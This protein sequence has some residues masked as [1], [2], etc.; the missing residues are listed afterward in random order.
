MMHRSKVYRLASFMVVFSM[1]WHL[2]L[3]L[4]RLPGITAV[5]AAQPLQQDRSSETAMPMTETLATSSPLAISRVQSSYTAPGTVAIT[6]TVH[7]TLSPVII[8]PA[9]A[10]PT[11]TDTLAALDGFDPL[12]D[13]NTVRGVLLTSELTGFGSLTTVH[14]LADQ[15][16]NTLAWNLGDIAPLQSATAVLTLTLSTTPSNIELLD[17]GATAYGHT[18]GQMVSANAAPALV[19]PA[20]F[21]QWLIWTLDAD[22]YNAEML[23]Q[24]GQLGHDPAQLFAYVQSLG[25]ELYDGSLRGTR[26]TLW[27]AAGN[28]ADQSSLLIAMLRASGIPTRYRYGTLSQTDAQTLLASMFPAPTQY[29]GRL[30]ESLA[31][32]DPVNDPT[33]IAQAQDHWWVEAY[34]DDGWVDLDP[35]FPTAQIGD[36]FAT[37]ANDGTDRLAELPDATRHKVTIRLK[38]EDYYPLNLGQSGLDYSY[39]LSHTFR[40][41]ELVAEPVAFS[42]LVHTDNQGGL[43]F[44]NTI[45]TYTPYLLIGERE[46]FGEPY[47]DILTNF[48]LGSVFHTAAWLQFDLTA[49]NGET[50]TYEREIVDKIG[51]EARVNGGN[52]NVTLAG[53]NARLVSDFDVYTTGFW[54][55]TVPETAVT[56]AKAA[57]LAQ[58]AALQAANLRLQ[59]LAAL[60]ELTQ[61]EQNEVAA[62]RARSQENT[63]RLLGNLGLSFAEMSDRMVSE[64]SAGLFIKAYYAAPRLI[65]TGVKPND[66]AGDFSMDLRNTAVRAIPFPGQA[67]DAATGFN[68]AKGFIESGIE[69]RTLEN[70]TGQPVLTTARISAAAQEQGIPP[71]YLASDNLNLLD[72]LDLSEQANARITSAT[73]AGKLVIIPVTRVQIDGGEHIGWWEIDPTSGETIGVIENG[74]HGALLEYLGTIE[75][76]YSGGAL[77]D[78]IMGMTAYL[79]GF[80]ADRLDKAIGDG[81]FDQDH[82]DWMIG[83]YATTLTCVGAAASGSGYLFCGTGA[84]GAAVGAAGGSAPLDPFAWGQ[85]AAKALLARLVDH[86]PPLPNTWLALDV[87]DP[88]VQN[89]ATA[90]L[91]IAATLPTGSLSANLTTDFAVVSGTLSASY[92]SPGAAYQYHAL[93]IA[94]GD[95]QDGDG[96]LIGSGAI[97]AE[98]GALAASAANNTLAGSGQMAFYAAA[99][100]AIGNGAHFAS[101][102]ADLTG[103]NLELALPD[104][105]VTLNTTTYTGDFTIQTQAVTVNG[106]GPLAAANHAA[107]ATLSG[108]D[109]AVTL[110]AASGTATLN[111]QLLDTSNGFAL[112]SYSGNVGLSDG[113]AAQQVTLDGTA[114]LFT[115]S[116]N[117]SA[118]ATTPATAVTFTPAIASNFAANFVLTL[119]APQ[120]WTAVWDGNQAT[121]TPVSGAAAG[122]YAVTLTA[123]PDS[124]PLVCQ[125]AVHIITVQPFNG[126]TLF[127]QPDPLTTIPMGD[128]LADNLRPGSTNSGQ[129][130]VPGAAYTILL[131]NTANAAHTYDFTVSGLPAGW[132]L[133]ANRAQGETSSSLTLPPGETGYLGLYVN[134]TGSQLPAPGTSHTIQVTAVSDTTA[135]QTANATFTMPAVPFNYVT[136]EPPVLY[137]TSTAVADIDLSIRNVGNAAGDFPVSARDTFAAIAVT[138]PLNG[139]DGLVPGATTTQQATIASSDAPVGS[140]YPVFFDSPAPDGV[141]NQ[142]ATLI[143]QIVSQRA[144]QLFQAGR[145]SA[146]N[147]GYAAASVQGLGT[148]VQEL[149]SWCELGDCPLPLRDNVVAAAQE[150]A[151]YGEQ[152]R[153]TTA[154]PGVSAAASQLAAAGDDAA[155][156]A[157][158]DGLV[159]AVTNLGDQVCEVEEHRPALRWNPFV[160]AILSGEDANYDLELS[161][162][163]TVETTYALSLTLP[164]GETAQSVTVPAGQTTTLPV[165]VTTPSNGYH[166]L[167]A[168]A[169]P[170]GPDVALLM[171]PDTRARLNVVDK[172]VQITAVSADPPFVDPGVSATILSVEIANIANVARSVVAATAVLAPDGSTQ[173]SLSP[174]LNLL[175]DNPRTY[176][177][178]TIDT[179]GWAEGVYTVTV[180]LLDESSVLVPDG[181]G[182]GYLGV[183]QSLTAQMGSVPQLAPPGTVTVTTLITTTIQQWSMVNGQF[184]IVHA[185]RQHNLY[186][187]PYWQVA[188][189]V[190]HQSSIA[191]EEA[192]AV[193]SP[194]QPET[195]VVEDLLPLAAEDV[196]RPLTYTPEEELSMAN[197][198]SP[199]TNEDAE[200]LLTPLAIDNLLLTIDDLFFRIEQDDPAIAYTGSWSSHSLA[201]ASGG[202]YWRN[203]TAGNTAALTFNG[204]WLNLGFIGGRWGGYVDITLNGNPQGS[205]DLYRRDDNSP[206]SLTF[207]DLGVGP[208]TVTM[209]VSGTSNPFSSGTRVQL[210]YV[211]YWDGTPLGDGTFEETAD[212][213]LRS[214]G[215]TDVAYANASGGGYIRGGTATLWL[216]FDGDSFSYQAIAYNLGGK[217]DLF[218]DGRYLDTIDLYHPNTAGNAI[219]RTF[220]Y[221]GLGAGSHL[222]QI[223]TYRGQTTLDAFTTPG[224]AP[225]TDPDPAPTSINRYEEEHPAILYNGVP[226]T[227]TVQSWGRNSSALASDGQ[228][229]RSQTANDTIQFEFNGRWLTLGFIAD[230]LSGQAEIF[231]DGVSQ[232]VVDLYRREETAVSHFFP[233]LINS[234]HTVSVTVLGTSHPHASNSR[235]QLDF[236][237]F[238]DGSGFDDG[239]FEEDDGR[240]FLNNNWTTISNANASSGNFI[241]HGD[242]NAWFYFE[243]DSFTYDA[244]AY[245]L[246]N[247]TTLYV[248]GEHLD[249]VNLFDTNTLNNAITRTFS[250]D[251]LGNG[252]HLLQISSYRGQTTLD[253]LT[254]PGNAPFT[255]PETAVVGITRFEEDHPA[256]RYNGVPYTQTAQSWSRVGNINSTRAS[257]GQ[258]IHSATMSDTISFDFESTWIGVGFATTRFGG[259]AEIAIDGDTVATVDLYTREEDTESIYF[260]GLSEGSHTITITVLGTRHPNA[261]NSHI[262][263][264]Y[265][266]V[267]DGQ[268]LPTGSF[269]ED[270]ARLFYSNGWG[271]SSDGSA[272]GGGFASSNSNVTAWFPFT[273]DSVTFH[274]WTAA[275]YHSFELK[276]DGVSQGIFNN[277]R[278]AGGARPF[279]FSGLGDGAH[280]LELRQYRGVATADLFITPATGDHYELP[281]PSGIIRFEEDHPDLRYN[282]YPY[283]T[284][285]QSWGTQSSLNQSSGGYNVNTSTAGNTLSLDFTGTWVGAGFLSGGTIEIFIDG[286]SQ[287]VYTTSN[288]IGGVTSLYF[289]DLISGTHTISITAVSG[290]LRPDFIEIWDGDPLEEGWYNADLDDYSGRFHYSGKHWWGQYQ[291]QYAHQG[292]YVSQSLINA[293]PNMWFTFV[294]NDLTL[295]GFNRNG[296]TLDVTIDG[297]YMGQL[298]MTAVY[299]DQP[300][301]FHFPDLGEG[302]HSVH[303]YTRGFGR[304]DAFEVNP[305]GF[306]SYTPQVTWHDD[307]ATEELDP[308]LGTGFV[309]TIALGDLNGD[310]IVELVA[311][312][313]NGRLYIYRGDGQD[314]GDGTPIQWHT[315]LVGQ[316]AEPA[317]GDLDG[318]GTAEIIISGA[319]GLFAFRH[320][321]LLLWH[322][323]D[324]Q[325]HTGDSGGTFGWGGPTLGNLDDTPEPEIVI[326]ASED[327]LYIVDHQGNI[328]DSDVIGRWPS[329]PV[330][331]DMTGDGTLDIISAQGHTLNLYDYNANGLEILWTY[332]LTNTTFRSGVFGSPAVADLTGDGQPEII[333][334]WGHVIE[335]FRADGSR[336]WSYETGDTN[337]FR[338]SPITVADVTG[339]GEIN[340]ITAS[341]INAGFLIFDHMLMVLTKDGELVWQQTVADSSAS[342]SG[343]AA[344]DLTGNGVWE[345]LWNGLGDGFLI[346][347]G[348]DGKRLFNEPF[349][350]SGTI[351]DYPTMGDVDG[352]GVAD[353]VVAGREG[354]FVISH[355]GHWVDSR[356]LWNQHNYHVTNIND[357]WSIPA[358]QPNSW[359]LHNSYRT[360]TPEQAPAPAYS[361]NV[362]YAAGI[363]QMTVLTPTISLPP[364]A[365][366]PPIYTFS[367]RQEWYQPVITFSL[368]SEA[369]DLQPGEVRQVA[370]GAVVTYTLPGGQNRLTLPPL[371][372]TG[373]AIA[374]LQPTTQTAVPGQTISYTLTLFNPAAVGDSYTLSISGLPSDWGVALPGSVIVPG[375]GETSLTLALTVP[376]NADLH[377][378]P[379]IVGVANGSGGVVQL[380]GMVVVQKGVAVAITAVDGNIAP[381]GQ[382]ISHT[383]TITNL[384][385]A[386]RTY[387]LSAA[388]TPQVSLPP[389][390]T[391][392]ANSSAAV[393]LTATPLDSGAQPFTVQVVAGENGA[394]GSATA[395]IQGLGVAG[396]AVTLAPPI[397]ETGPGST[398]VFTVTLQNLGSSAQTFD[399]S[400][401]LPQEWGGQFE[402][403]GQLVTAVFVASGVYNQ[404]DLTLRVTV[405]ETAVAGTLPISV[406]ATLPENPAVVGSA[407]SEVI[408]TDFGVHVEILD[409]ALQVAPADTA[410]WNV[411]LTNT[412]E[413][414]DTFTLLAAGLPVGADGAFSS[415]TVTLAAGASTVVQYTAGPFTGALPQWYSFDVT[416]QSVGNTAVFST[417]RVTFAI[418]GQENLVVAWQPA[419]QTVTNTVTA[420]FSLVITNTGNTLAPLTLTLG[421]AGL[422]AHVALDSFPLPPGM[423]AV[424]PVPVTAVA[425]GEYTLTGMAM[426]DA[427]QVED[428]AVLTVIITDNSQPRL[429]Y[430]PIIRHQPT[431]Q[432]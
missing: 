182:L 354:I 33:L 179:S 210:D 7:N 79:F 307:S 50:A 366:S 294:G 37:P 154:A 196:I 21:A 312:A 61:A 208:H 24:A 296:A 214:N 297:Q 175:S 14:P 153:Y 381:L 165:P 357:D 237:D 277:Y 162:L 244:L 286:D 188:P 120:G 197:G 273:G 345:I 383:L 1:F 207:A 137:L 317:L 72:Q 45:H 338:P 240:L 181:S 125:T 384:E 5:A 308:A 424:V 186:N 142:T 315:D 269:E 283:E 89:V 193:G 86:D 255:D 358:V 69:G 414:D 170:T 336:L 280:V 145:C 292:D 431:A 272:S 331:A 309:S 144:G 264:D 411:R 111:G 288:T 60:P 2:L 299:S 343:V 32:A 127:V 303:L 4:G 377:D 59:E 164:T 76:L 254:T 391:V 260:D 28:S 46:I 270:D 13:P 332:T 134:P 91:P 242:G 419:S 47:Q 52:T 349:T 267:W 10:S 203:A 420:T 428:T 217:A 74:L 319:N 402:A 432:N 191:N 3:P 246:G 281:P 426:G 275:N 327:A 189:S 96:V 55:N 233:D 11:I 259:Q 20:S 388:G 15:Q 104:T 392:P 397:V 167:E 160:D 226:Y 367:Y 339:D 41:V 368:V 284:M 221:E 130:Q 156:L 63:A 401:Q 304:V 101:A 187:A 248:D 128:V 98:S 422:A 131:T 400:H 375:D 218:V 356:P 48:P 406:T 66:G 102:Q 274:S 132:T 42:H 219:T 177:L 282:G 56:Q 279:S 347:R 314:A 353:V 92:A 413:N 103:S 247:W 83:T 116:A 117:P 198:Q 206:I 216:P 205:F 265:F 305:D 106:S 73:A 139:A 204:D 238:G 18:A 342:A 341:A 333:I 31:T 166:L 276:I 302:P 36:S 318:D 389:Q 192:T 243:G 311:P 369:A 363:E 152:I 340:L 326:A 285:P 176:E 148:A 157:A 97:V 105:A 168:V 118:S 378:Y 78:F 100:P 427:M 300:I 348:S 324:I 94:N 149:E 257:D 346:I 334:N 62:L 163:G 34:L 174:T 382:P 110:G 262:Y 184:P 323:P 6:Y 40:T 35:S 124:A 313:Q 418:I 227:Q 146:G 374:E 38:V 150:V 26:G 306:Y 222:L 19:N 27:S 291:N 85:E 380:G 425:A 12:R 365:V 8:P 241:R 200:N 403:D 268:P 199:M 183:G 17:N 49:P 290:S 310:G 316:A 423:V 202:T 211:D 399:L 234:T 429:L 23:A 359:E 44:A 159:T 122:E 39:P 250:Y 80:I 212:R 77:T 161:N 136:V 95:L 370:Q 30:E 119:T 417:D 81:T 9:P 355:V 256:I 228:Y 109:L 395:V 421:G 43:V 251:G 232:G 396:V 360:Q 404:A 112:A 321:G 325:A 209:T 278:Y 393:A 372:V 295:L 266:D 231:I 171:N 352:D 229:L 415:E 194:I 99:L 394:Q 410:V 88:A 147:R 141:Y 16:D 376:E 51:Y 123:C 249:T 322:D 328:L 364:T 412:G 129:A 138:S 107:S 75:F 373:A 386:D 223:S 407:S 172:F 22:I 178:G 239:A 215:W 351:M 261:T 289:D 252:R 409:T 108:S 301:T 58:S 213:V 225:F 67:A 337:H 143:V 405:P 329:V 121:I 135:Q 258:Y 371:Y 90:T 126:F 201:Q 385:G 230:R 158:L 287:G 113:G 253:A 330:L 387:A 64:T 220:S 263:L 71:V 430:L 57:A 235:V 25:Y 140:V 68:I 151:A 361:V 53:D 236:I 87:F 195:A 29:V 180:N 293:N 398:A 82:Y 224:T 408:V 84:A 320:D 173:A 390:V 155:I 70:S 190:N 379:F 416:A 65:I 298:D 133:L 115:L 245:N 350:R 93:T 335:A 271:Q 185:L 114:V 169:V 54:P 344:Q 362:H